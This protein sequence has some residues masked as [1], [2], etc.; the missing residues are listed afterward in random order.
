MLELAQLGLALAASGEMLAQARGLFG[1]EPI[2]CGEWQQRF[3]FVVRHDVYRS[4]LSPSR[5]LMSAVR[6]RVFTVPSGRP[7]LAA[8]SV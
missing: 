5:S 6:I 8:I 3:E 1:I 7:T 2:E 4:R